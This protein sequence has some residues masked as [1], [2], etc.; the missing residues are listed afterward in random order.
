MVEDP[1]RLNNHICDLYEKVFTQ[2]NDEAGIAKHGQ[3]AV[4][5]LFKEFEQLHDKRVLKQLKRAIYHMIRRKMPYTRL[6]SSKKKET[7]F[8][9]ERPW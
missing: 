9:K 3:D 6:T 4:A 1:Q 5:A 2:M 8:E 7:V